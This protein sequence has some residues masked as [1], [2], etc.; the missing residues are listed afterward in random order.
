M[1]NDGKIGPPSK[2]MIM[3]RR[4]SFVVDESVFDNPVV[5]VAAV[6]VVRAIAR[7]TESCV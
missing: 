3:M 1:K 7:E 5:A 6:V 4:N 2:K